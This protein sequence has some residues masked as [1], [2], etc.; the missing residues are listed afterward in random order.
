VLFQYLKQVHHDLHARVALR[1]RTNE[2][3]KTFELSDA[4]EL[5]N[6]PLNFNLIATSKL[7]TDIPLFRVKETNDDSPAVPVQSGFGDQSA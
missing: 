7:L 5:K 6:T 4:E 1:I 3:V 2:I